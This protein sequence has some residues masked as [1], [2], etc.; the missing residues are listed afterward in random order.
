MNVVGCMCGCR[1]CEC[2]FTVINL[3]NDEH[4]NTVLILLILRNLWFHDFKIVHESFSNSNLCR[5]TLKMDAYHVSVD[6]ISRL[7]KR[8]DTFEQRLK[9]L[10]IEDHGNSSVVK[11]IYNDLLGDC[12]ADH[13][14]Q[15]QLF[16]HESQV[17]S[18]S[19]CADLSMVDLDSA[20]TTLA[21]S[22]PNQHSIIL[23]TA[24]PSQTKIYSKD[25]IIAVGKEI[26]DPVVGISLFKNIRTVNLSSTNSATTSSKIP[27]SKQS[28][29]MLEPYKATSCSKGKSSRVGMYK[30][31]KSVSDSSKMLS[32]AK[33]IKR[34]FRFGLLVEYSDSEDS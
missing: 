22:V 18:T 16:E 19:S 32:P 11:S 15:R 17:I 14:Q 25:Q 21:N 6:R 10:E 9:S 33:P 27:M 3:F 1:I 5:S 28:E 24:S 8:M 4:V 26:C 12:W 29:N 23:G 34:E 13:C 2:N 7:E 31:P 30:S 20:N